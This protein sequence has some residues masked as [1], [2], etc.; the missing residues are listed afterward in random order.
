MIRA[1]INDVDEIPA[2][3]RQTKTLGSKLF[4]KVL[5]NTCVWE[6]WI[7]M[8]D[9]F[10]DFGASVDSCRENGIKAPFINSSPLAYACRTGNTPMVRLLL[11]R[12]LDAKYAMSY[13]A[14]G[15]NLELVKLLLDHGCDPNEGYP[16]PIA[17]AVDL[18]HEAMFKHLYEHGAKMILP[19][20]KQDIVARAKCAGLES[21]LSLLSRK[22]GLDTDGPAY[23]TPLPRPRKLCFMC[24]PREPLGSDND[25]E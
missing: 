12:G 1:A 6:G 21:M 5:F 25:E 23:T 7:T 19:S 8:A 18:E 13:A 3:Q 15:G 20:A 22:G 4:F 9:Y 14:A 11:N 17:W 2:R 16:P 10:L 24:E